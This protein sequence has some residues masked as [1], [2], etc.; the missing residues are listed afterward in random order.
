MPTS[1]LMKA[2]ANAANE[3]KNSPCTVKTKDQIVKARKTSIAIVECF[4][5]SPFRIGKAS[6][7]LASGKRLV[8]AFFSD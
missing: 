7:A 3:H 4:I 6:Y 8:K 1:Q 2:I 5:C